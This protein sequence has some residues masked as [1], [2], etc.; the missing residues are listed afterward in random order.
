[1]KPLRKNVAISIDGGGIR[2]VIVTRALTMLEEHLG[3]SIYSRFRLMA[4]T[5]TGAIIAASLGAGLSAKRLDELYLQNGHEIF[6][7]SWR[8]LVWPLLARYRYALEPLKIALR[9]EIGDLT[10]GDLWST[11]PPTDVVITLFDLVENRSRFV[12]S[13]K[14]EYDDWP[15][16]KAILA[17]SSVPTY[18]PVVDGRYVDGGVG[19]YTNPC[20]LA[21][22]EMQFCLNWDLAETTLISLG[23]GRSPHTLQSGEA[24]KFWAWDWIEP[25][26]GAFAQSADDQQV[27]LVQTFFEQLDFRR[28]QVD[29]QEPI[30]MD[31]ASKIPE[32]VK[33]GEDLGWKILNNET[34]RA[35]QIQ[36]TQAPQRL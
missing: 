31:D 23:T 32:L 29:L 27:H 33:Y 11:E 26:L 10:M 13:W 18:F 7:P 30:G 16:Y 15:V 36:A 17:S 2:G 12:K 35:Q 19:S 3:Q 14:H 22:Y 20:Y 21:A 4:G 8:T 25:V 34:D 9:Q 6:Q 28:F 1:M 24:D 5:S